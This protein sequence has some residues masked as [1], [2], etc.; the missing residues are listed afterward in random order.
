MGLGAWGVGTPL[1]PPMWW[2]L[3]LID[4]GSSSREE[5]EFPPSHKYNLR[6]NSTKEQIINMILLIKKFGALTIHDGPKEDLSM[7]NKE[8]IKFKGFSTPSFNK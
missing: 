6:S 5:R 2:S 4:E 3:T 7:R 8:R 1:N